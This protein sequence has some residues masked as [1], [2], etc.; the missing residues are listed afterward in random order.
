MNMY[1]AY[2]QDIKTF[3]SWLLKEIIVEVCKMHTVLVQKVYGDQNAVI[4]SPEK[5]MLEWKT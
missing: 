3:T 4:F 5:R 2:S 1:V